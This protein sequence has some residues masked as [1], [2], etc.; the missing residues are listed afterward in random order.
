MKRF[1]KYHT[2][3]KVTCRVMS[4]L[5]DKTFKAVEKEPATEETEETEIMWVKNMQS[6]MINRK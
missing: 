1:N 4:V 5:K 3:L 6:D 2:L